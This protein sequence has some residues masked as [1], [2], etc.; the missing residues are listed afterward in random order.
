M[1]FFSFSFIP[2]LFFFLILGVLHM[3]SFCLLSKNVCEKKVSGYILRMSLS[4]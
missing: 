2:F 1:G 3:F 4:S